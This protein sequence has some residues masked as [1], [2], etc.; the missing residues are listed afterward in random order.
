MLAERRL[1]GFLALSALVG[2]GVGLGAAALVLA[3]EGIGNLLEPILDPLFNADEIG[4]WDIRRAWI[5][6][7]VPVGLVAAWFIARR[8][9]PE[10]AGDGV[11][12]AAA[13]LAVHGGRIRKRVA[14]L[15]IV[16]TAIT[17]GF[18]GSAGREG[19]VVQIGAAV[20]S[21]ISRT[22]KLGEDE[23]RS[24]VAAGA[25]AGIGAS[26]NAPIAGM[27]FALEVI[28]SSFAPR[29][30]SSIVIAS[31]AAAITTQSIVGEELALS[32]GTY[33]M[34]GFSELILYAA[35]TVV[36][37][38][39]GY[40]FLKLLDWLEKVAHRNDRTWSW[41]RPTGFG[42]IVAG[43]IFVEPRLFGTGQEF[44]NRL[45]LDE[46]ISD[47]TGAAGDLWWVLILLALGKVVATSF[48]ISSGASGGAFM[49][50]LFMGAALGAGFARLVQPLWTFTELDTGAFAVVGMAA[51]FAMV[52]R[53]P[54]TSILIVF[55]ITGAR[56]Y[57]L[58]VPLMLAA[59][60]ATFFGE[61][62][63]KES[64]Y[65]AAL[66][67]KGIRIRPAGD[68][69][70]LDTVNV[71]T[72]MAPNPLMVGPDATIGETEQRLHQQRS[73]GVP[74]IEDDRLIGIVTVSDISR[75][76]GG[77][78]TPV[79]DVMTPRPVTVTPS[80]PVSRA[81]ERMA[82]LGIGRLPVVAEH[83]PEEVVGMFRREEAVRAYHEGLNATTDSELHRMRLAQRTD[84][85]AGYFDFRIPLG[86]M[87][88]G[89]LVREVSW[90]EGSTLV[91]VRRNREVL[92]PSG[93]TILLAGDVVT[94][95]GTETSKRRMI[96]RLNSGADEPTA[97]IELPE[98][99]VETDEE[100]TQS[101]E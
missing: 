41:M 5:F 10:V 33:T 24:L 63:A 40:F 54:L 38:A 97:E 34:N 89:R 39:V 48:T 37:V 47:V 51:M 69:D 60:L 85:G 83:N 6:L 56:D 50:S 87:A 80:T 19:P 93:S 94:A 52:G 76:E 29:H 36:I 59:T 79:R 4:F 12:E 66:K 28:L 2:V 32:A 27:L 1:G 9:A 13:A 57:G 96:D 86:S 64:V 14:P 55:E 35:M 98:F 15:K 44:T 95:F 58:I 100:S 84:P 16:V 43:L 74:V 91:S 75:S 81:L 99:G 11:P 7:T 18:G 26:F 3:L 22:F 46:T 72:V 30:M 65:T 71:G 42:L 23:V 78:D 90:P 82:A 67:R 20:G 62:F 53:A 61:R 73:H 49:P 21:W 88:D 8:F 77:P 70:I 25:G 101:S 92:V 17:I 31:V 68:V 45:L